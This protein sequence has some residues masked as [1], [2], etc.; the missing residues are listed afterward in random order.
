MDLMSPWTEDVGAVQTLACTDADVETVTVTLS[1]DK[2]LSALKLFMRV[3][4]E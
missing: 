1:A 4:A 3:T 2:P